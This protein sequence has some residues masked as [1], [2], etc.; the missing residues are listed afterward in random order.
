MGEPGKA[1]I[2]RA[3]SFSRAFPRAY[4]PEDMR[5]AAR[6]SLSWSLPSP[7]VPSRVRMRGVSWVPRKFMAERQAK[8]G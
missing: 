6:Q 5:K 7:P 3:P 8:G 4:W 1:K 2:T